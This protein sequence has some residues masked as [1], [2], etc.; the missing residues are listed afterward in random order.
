MSV[1]VDNM[2]YNHGPISDLS[3]S[4]GLNLYEYFLQHRDEKFVRV[5]GVPISI[6]DNERRN[7]SLHLMDT[8]EGV[9]IECEENNKPKVTFF[10]RYNKGKCLP[11]PSISTRC[12]GN[13]TFF[14]LPYYCIS[15][16]CLFQGMDI[17]IEGNEK[18]Y[19][20]RTLGCYLD[21]PL[22]LSEKYNN[23]YH[24]PTGIHYLSGEMLNYPLGDEKENLYQIL[25]CKEKGSPIE[26]S[27]LNNKL[28]DRNILRIIS[29]NLGKF[30]FDFITE[31]I[32]GEP[33]RP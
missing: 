14:A 19:K 25:A 33:R 29:S 16:A 12:Q 13:S 28:Y 31:Q 32:S 6:L 11:I 8:F 23:M 9:L 18:E 2:D 17:L 26:R 15:R 5:Y 1:T 30:H 4:N 10:F 7:I 20:V 3:L 21:N 22:R 24:A 27:L